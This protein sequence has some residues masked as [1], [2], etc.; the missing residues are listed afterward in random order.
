MLVRDIATKNPKTVTTEFSIGQAQDLLRNNDFRHV[1]V[2]DGRRNVQGIV[3]ETDVAATASMARI[4]DQDRESYE[5]FLET[6][7][8]TLLKTR[9][10]DEDQGLVTVSADDPV[11]EAVRTLL[12]H[13]LSAVL[14]L[15]EDGTL[16]GILSYVDLLEAS[17]QDGALESP[18][19]D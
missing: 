12:D 3:S 16:F 15:A 10:D 9:F 6:S 17:L 19:G 4:F 2:V 11:D 1:P 18:D 14:V 5:D 13:R 8:D 7:V